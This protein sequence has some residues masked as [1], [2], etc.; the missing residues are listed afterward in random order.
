ME[1]F[2]HKC[3]GPTEP[4]THPSR[5]SPIDGGYK[6]PEVEIVNLAMLN[7]A[8]SLGNHRSLIFDVSTRSVLGKFRYKVC[9]PVS[10]QLVTSQASSFKQYNEIVQEQF[11][12]HRIVKRMDAVD[13][14][15]RYCGYPSPRWLCAMIIKLYKQMTEIRVHAKKKCRKILKPDSN[16]SPTI[17]MWYDRIH[18]YLQ[19]I[20]IKE[21]KAKNT[22]NILRF[23]QCQ[24]INDPEKLS[25]EELREGLHARIRKADLRRQANGLGKVHL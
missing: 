1:E 5:K 17:Q 8:E 22:A 12:I 24:H 25:L 13:K 9:R 4:Y 20:R 10:R 19:L 6:S 23:A 15:T 18:A 11:K 3:W 16:F 14:M 2:S 21:G 7:F